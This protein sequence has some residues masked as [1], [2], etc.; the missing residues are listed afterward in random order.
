MKQ[1]RDLSIMMKHI[2]HRIVL[3]A[4]AAL[5]I[6][7]VG[8]VAY[9][10]IFQT[11]LTI[12]K[13]G[14]QPGYIIF[15]APDGNVYAVDLKGNVAMKWAS[16][17]A[18]TTFGYAR[19]LENGNLLAR[20]QPVKGAPKA[21]E[22]PYAENIS[23]D[24]VVEF[25]QE[26]QVVWRY[27]ERTRSL[28]HDQERAADGNT[29]LVCAKDIDVPAISEKRIHDDCL[30]EVD[31]TGKVVWEWQTADH[32]DDLDLSERAKAEIMQGPKAEPRRLEVGAPPP[33]NGYDWAHMNAASVIPANAGN[34]DPRFRAGNIIAS[35]RNLNTI[36]VVDRDTKKIVWKAIGTTIGQHNTHVIPDGLPGAGHILVFDNGNNSVN[37]NPRRTEDRPNSR[38]VEIDPANGSVVWEYTAEKSHQPIWT[39]FSHYISSVQRQPNGNTLIDEGANGRFFEVTPQGEIGRAHV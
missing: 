9:P 13:P 29:L 8:A 16:P 1:Q 11:G 32:Y 25:T 6:A 3:P 5:S 15:A 23:A 24:S 10:S 20:L 31:K 28:H 4:A 36:V 18:N 26:G 2:L 38:G 27:V 7:V 39:F 37:G 22:D 33:V 35:Y 34:T 30:I 17:V 21:A 14:V 12:S 19:P